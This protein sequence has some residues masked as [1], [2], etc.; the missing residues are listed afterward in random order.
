MTTKRCMLIG[1]LSVLVFV[2]AHLGYAQLS[3]A[4]ELTP[5][6]QVIEGA[7]K[8]GKEGPVNATIIAGVTPK[9]IPRLRSEIKK[10]YGV[11]LDIT[12]TPSTDYPKFYA[13]ALME[14]K[15]A[16]P[17]SYDLMTFNAY[18][19]IRGFSEGIF[20]KLDWRPLLAKGAP[21]EVLS[22]T[23]PQVKELYGLG[24]IYFSSDRGI[25]YNPE[26][27]PADKVPKT[28]AD[29]ADPQWKGKVGVNNYPNVWA[30]IAFIRGKEKTFSDL[31]AMLKNEAIQGLYTDVFNRYLLGEVPIIYVTSQYLEYARAKGMPSA[32]QTLEFSSMNLY[33]LMLRKG[34][35]RPNAAKL[36]AIYLAS[37]AGA[38]FMLEEAHVGNLYYPGN[39]EHDI[40]LQNEKQGLRVVCKDAWPEL[41]DF[42]VGKEVFLWGKEITLI[43]QT[44]GR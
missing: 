25:I 41:M 14:K 22:G 8:E 30:E 39:F 13:E 16:A 32:W 28:I 37:P 18:N 44:G 6:A 27:I 2:I 4:A 1:L 26:R 34:T 17:P 11:D 19:G 3:S 20:E 35:R 43:F 7:K 40:K 29:L 38:R 10:E 24:L 31:R 15:I 36:V 9:S 5:L 23:P 21:P 42:L 12:I 33:H